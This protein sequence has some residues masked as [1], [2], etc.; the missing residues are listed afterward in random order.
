MLPKHFH[1]I[2]FTHECPTKS[3]QDHL[4]LLITYL[5]PLPI[6]SSDWCLLS[7]LLNPPTGELSSGFTSPVSLPA[8]KN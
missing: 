2:L 5:L 7:G 4:S 8:Q 3:L 6:I 1:R